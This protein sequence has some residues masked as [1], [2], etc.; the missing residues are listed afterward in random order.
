[1][2]IGMAAAKITAGMCREMISPELQQYWDAQKRLEHFKSGESGPRRT[3]GLLRFRHGE[4]DARP[5]PGVHEDHDR[6]GETSSK[7]VITGTARF[8]EA[9]FLCADLR[10]AAIKGG[11]EFEATCDRLEA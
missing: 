1:M 8:H 6:T 5:D 7:L 10:T 3:A 2:K 4:M 11:R 9:P